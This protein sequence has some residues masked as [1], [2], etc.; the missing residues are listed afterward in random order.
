[1]AIIE[2]ETLQGIK[3]VEIEGD[4]P[5]PEEMDLINNTFFSG[6]Y[7]DIPPDVS[8]YQGKSLGEA[9][10]LQTGDVSDDT[11]PTHDGEIKDA[12]FQAYFGRADD[13][14]DK[15]LRLS[16]KFGEGTFFQDRQ[17]NFVLDLD[18][19]GEEQ[20]KELGLPDSGTIYANKPG[21]TKYDAVG[22]LANEFLPLTGAIGA[23]IAST[24][25]G[26]MA[27]VGLI[28]LGTMAGKALD[29]YIIEDIFEGAQ[30]QSNEDVLKDVLFEG[31]LALGSEVVFR[32]VGAGI[33]RL[34]KG[35][36]AVPDENIRLRIE[37]EFIKNGY[38]EK[39]ARK[40][41]FSAAREEQAVIMRQ[42]IEEGASIPVQTLSGKAILGRTQA[43]YEQIFPNDELAAQNAKFVRDKLEEVRKGIITKE[44]AA[45]SVAE[46][47]QP[48]VERLQ[49]RM[50]NKK[51]AFEDANNAINRILKGQMDELEQGFKADPNLDAREFIDAID[52]AVK[53]F[54]LHSK[55][56]YRIAED[57]L[58]SEYATISL[59]N[60]KEVLEKSG[61]TAGKIVDE[62][63]VI[64][65]R[66][67]G[68]AGLEEIKDLPIFD[69]LNK[70]DSVNIKDLP[71]LKAAIRASR[72]DPRIKGQPADELVG[73]LIQS[74]DNS[75]DVKI[76]DLV[77]N[78]LKQQGPTVNRTLKEGIEN[79]KKANKYYADGMDIIDTGFNNSLKN[80]IDQGFIQ[81]FRGVV[82]TVVKNGQPNLFRKF[83]QSIT[84]SQGQA[85]KILDVRKSNNPTVLED[86]AQLVE[87]GQ[88]KL[89]NEML[90][91]AGL[92]VDK[93]NKSNANQGILRISDDLE[94]LP[95]DDFTRQSAIESY[96]K[97]LRDYDDLSKRNL[98]PNQF[99]GKFRDQIARQWIDQNI[100]ANSGIGSYRKLAERYNNLGKPL[101]K[102]L[103]GNRYQ[104]V[105]AIM[106]RFELAD[107]NDA[108]LAAA[109][110]SLTL[111]GLTDDA[112][113]QLTQVLDK[114]SKDVTRL[115]LQ[116]EDAFLKAVN[117]QDF[118]ATKLIDH[119]IKNPKS[120]TRLKN[121]LPPGSEGL[122]TVE[123]A[124]IAR[125]L[126]TDMQTEIGELIQTGKFNQQLL[127]KMEKADENGL[128]TE[129]LG[130]EFVENIKKIGQSGNITSDAIL[131]G[132]TGLASAAYAAGFAGAFILNPL[133]ALGGAAL[134]LGFSKALRSPAVMKFFTSPRLRAYAAERA[135]EGGGAQ[136]GKR[137]LAAEKAIEAANA[138]VRQIVAQLGQSG[139]SD[140]SERIRGEITPVV[141]DAAEEFS[142]R[143]G[144]QLLDEEAF[145]IQS[146]LTLPNTDPQASML[147]A[148]RTTTPGMT[149]SEVYRNQE[150]QKLLGGIPT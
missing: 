53:L 26:T 138:A 122:E 131:K 43:I 32:G 97:V 1:M 81:D 76:N 41:S 71:A 125:I 67:I 74:L 15:A 29:E 9:R 109:A 120:L 58:G 36:G 8:P 48:L 147:Q 61:I 111:P 141:E 136:L 148:P 129:L 52:P 5:T 73:R 59:S 137:N 75:M 13:N 85:N 19:I 105:D 46:E 102:E 93:V 27:G 87:Q 40:L 35:K 150:L 31:A 80:Q 140:S 78:V 133:A 124:L 24:G 57:G 70:F 94:K 68:K 18:K 30:A 45:N 107:L 72:A 115:E 98:D 99:V 12:M 33:K 55:N 2:V 116:G 10:A 145:N 121:E 90:D 49:S 92:I 66:Q 84:P 142:E 146:P 118:D 144:D 21:F 143:V 16:N 83:L 119:L 64:P 25:V 42:M 63:G 54:N 62:G 101:Q 3:K 132:K 79:L 17:G 113:K 106:K 39:E 127:Q 114:L 104:E 112:T 38:S 82:D 117:G 65:E 139:V 86:A 77:A 123:E 28:S 11:K 89:A 7:E 22:F 95:V 149:A 91:E 56:L 100:V 103:F 134:I 135:I 47:L 4:T 128:V 37:K 110:K 69:L 44:E 20:K 23:G 6:I 130:K 50:V 51:T 96:A 88:I 14:D 34:A 108:S 60:L 126:P